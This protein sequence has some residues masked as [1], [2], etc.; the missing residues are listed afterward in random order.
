MFSLHIKIIYNVGAAGAIIEGGL[1][2]ALSPFSKRLPSPLKNILD[3]GVH[4]LGSWAQHAIDGEPYSFKDA[5][6]EFGT[7][8]A[9]NSKLGRTIQDVIKKAKQLNKIINTGCNLLERYIEF[10]REVI[11]KCIIC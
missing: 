10:I 5:V 9:K 2:N 1:N 7:E 8:V 6:K 4:V 3:S 11:K